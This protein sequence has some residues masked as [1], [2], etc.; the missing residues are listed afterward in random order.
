MLR[1]LKNYIKTPKGFGQYVNLI[2][3]FAPRKAGK[4]AFKVFCTPRKG[5]TFNKGQARII[6]Q[7]SQERL[8]LHDF[9]L[10]TYAWQ[11]EDGAEKVLLVHGW[12]SNAARLRPG[13]STLRSAGY[14]VICFDAPG[15]GQSGSDTINGVLY[16]EAIEKVAKRFQPNYVVGHS[17]GGMGA[18]NYFANFEDV[19]SIKRLILMATPS[20]LS[21]VLS[22]YYQL[23][24]LK[25]R[26]QKAVDKYF[27]KEF[28]FDI[29]QF[30]IEEFAKKVKIP[31]LVI[32]DKQDTTTPFQEG[33]F[34]H[35][36]WEGSSL[37]AVDGAGH[38]LQTRDI[39]KQILAEIQKG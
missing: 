12:D 19:V 14:T 32:H 23:I 3:I 38:S 16:A 35:Q 17:F 34:I 22:D 7:A 24:N 4:L 5:R 37:L 27:K 8:S 1:K 31:G 36:N 21:R 2:S 29:E 13:I 33:Q 30:T 18:G 20:K 26:T 15:H 11:G 39:Y 25:E 28:G 6:S 9:E 10:Q